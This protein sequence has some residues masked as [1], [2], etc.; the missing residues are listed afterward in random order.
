MSQTQLLVQVQYMGKIM[1]YQSIWNQ[2][3]IGC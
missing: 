3:K 1:I 2:M